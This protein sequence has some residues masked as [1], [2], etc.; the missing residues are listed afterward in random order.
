MECLNTQVRGDVVAPGDYAFYWCLGSWQNKPHEIRFLLCY[1]LSLL[2]F[3]A[4]NSM[5]ASKLLASS[6]QGSLWA[7]E[8]LQAL[9]TQVGKAFRSF[10]PSFI[11]VFIP[12]YLQ[13]LV[14]KTGDW[15]HM[16]NYHAKGKVF[17]ESLRCPTCCQCTGNEGGN[18]VVLK[19]GC[20]L[21]KTWSVKK[22]KMLVPRSHPRNS[23]LIGKGWKLDIR[24]FRT[25]PCGSRT[26]LCVSHGYNH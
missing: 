11:H 16:Q 12:C 14:H 23:D 17:E 22:K 5:I 26:Q 4:L 15:K 2:W 7:L 10:L 18:A 13:C 20:T 19:L 3:C 9:R 21:K 1:P 8:V 25:P 24:C 6:L